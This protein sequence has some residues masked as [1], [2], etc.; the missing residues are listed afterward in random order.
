MCG[1]A[2]RTQVM[3]RKTQ[4]L[5]KGP[6]DCEVTKGRKAVPRPLRQARALTY[7][8]IDCW[9]GNEGGTKFKNLPCSTTVLMTNVKVKSKAF[10]LLR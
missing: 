4:D 5:P 1:R 8:L 9:R 7:C 3:Q 2:L 6:G 10:S